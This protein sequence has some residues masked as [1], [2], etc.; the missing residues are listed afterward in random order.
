MPVIPVDRVVDKKKIIGKMEGQGRGEAQGATDTKKTL[1]IYI[2]S[3]L[4]IWLI[5]I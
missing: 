1:P 5:N 2:C 3:L 4:Y